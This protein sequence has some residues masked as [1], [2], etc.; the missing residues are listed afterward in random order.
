ME[1][2]SWEKDKPKDDGEDRGEIRT[3]FSTSTSTIALSG[4]KQC[5]EHKW[6]K[7]ND[8]ELA[9]ADCPTAIICGIDDDRLLL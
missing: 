3:V 5:V 1:G 4:V 6:R 7:L 9:C 8:T 2:K